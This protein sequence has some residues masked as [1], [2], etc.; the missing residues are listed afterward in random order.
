M[1][2]ALLGDRADDDPSLGMDEAPGVVGVEATP[3]RA[4][5]ADALQPAQEALQSFPARL[6]GVQLDRRQVLGDEPHLWGGGRAK[7]KAV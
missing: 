5:D 4:L 3:P 6:D 7:E 2:V 1:K